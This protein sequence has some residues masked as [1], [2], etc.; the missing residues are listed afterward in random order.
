MK[1]RAAENKTSITASTSWCHLDGLRRTTQARILSVLLYVGTAWMLFGMLCVLFVHYFSKTS[2]AALWVANELFLWD[3]PREEHEDVRCGCAFLV[4]WFLCFGSVLLHYLFDLQ[5]RLYGV[6]E[7][8]RDATV[9]RLRFDKKCADSEN[10]SDQGEDDEGYNSEMKHG[11]KKNKSEK[12]CWSLPCSSLRAGGV[13]SRT[14]PPEYAVVQVEQ[15]QVLSEPSLAAGRRG[16]DADGACHEFHQG[17]G[18][19]SAT[20]RWFEYDCVCYELRQQTRRG[21]DDDDVFKAT[22]ST[23]DNEQ[24]DKH[25]FQFEP[26]IPRLEYTRVSARTYFE[27]KLK[28]SRTS[29]GEDTAKKILDAIAL[30]EVQAAEDDDVSPAGGAPAVVACSKIDPYLFLQAIMAAPPH[31]QEQTELLP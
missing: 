12:H 13:A 7:D 19:S 29:M 5:M 8:L 16:D 27:A 24:A 4:Y 31:A 14:R 20:K 23:S 22:N 10:Y 11:R 3:F 21:S 6:A 28:G 15:A 25:N 17:R 9:V 30:Q 18:P 2:D 26:V 1:Q